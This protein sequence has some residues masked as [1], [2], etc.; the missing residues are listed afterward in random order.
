MKRGR[1]LFQKYKKVLYAM[2]KFY[3]CFP[4]KMRKRM[5]ENSLK[6][7]GMVAIGKRYALLKSLAKS[8]G[9]NVRINEN[10][11]IYCPE[12]LV[13]GNNVSI[14]PMVYIEA[15]GGVKIGN[16]VSIAH[17]VTI[18]SEEHNFEMHDKPIKDQGKKFAPVVIKDNV[19]IGA[20]VVILSGV[21]IESGAIVGAGAV[22]TRDVPPNSIVAGVPAKVI[23]NR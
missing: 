18:M 6:K 3:S 14:W 19:W 4:K 9:D 11:Y 10:S 13:I 17:N 23:K 5:L 1:D 15:S 2:E 16:D 22:V 21:T 12:N 20:Q 8:V 7:R